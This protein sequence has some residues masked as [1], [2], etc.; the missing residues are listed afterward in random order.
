[1]T[2]VL[3]VLLKSI[4]RSVFASIDD[5]FGDLRQVRDLRA[6]NHIRNHSHNLFDAINRSLAAQ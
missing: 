4:C 3:Q 6:R 5:G 1:M 2:A